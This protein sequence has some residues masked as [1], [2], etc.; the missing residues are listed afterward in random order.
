MKEAEMSIEE[1]INSETEK[2]LKEM[3]QPGYEF[4]KKIGK[5]DIAVMA[6]GFVV[7]LLLIILCMT[8]VIK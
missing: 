3:E 2:R 4:P 5:A 8:G 7:S 6:A 1:L